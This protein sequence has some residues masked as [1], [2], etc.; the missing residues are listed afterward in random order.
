MVGG[1]SL[2][3]EAQ[4]REPSPVA[5]RQAAGEASPADEGG[6]AKAACPPRRGE[7]DRREATW[8]ATARVCV[9]GEAIGEVGGREV[10]ADNRRAQ[11]GGARAW[12]GAADHT[13]DGRPTQ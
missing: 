8:A 3:K 1:E 6:G 9:D 2:P 13:H 12:V 5:G 4:R 7:G 10:R 11:G